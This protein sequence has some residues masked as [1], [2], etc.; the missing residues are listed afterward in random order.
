M[1]NLILHA[2]NCIHLF[3]CLTVNAMVYLSHLIQAFWRFFL[4]LNF[5]MYQAEFALNLMA[6]YCQQGPCHGKCHKYGFEDNSWRSQPYYY[7]LNQRNWD[8]NKLWAIT[9]YLSWSQ[10]CIWWI[11]SQLVGLSL[12]KNGK[13][14]VPYGINGILN[15]WICWYSKLAHIQI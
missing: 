4:S 2:L 10:P 14:C 8:F 7:C 15:V 9:W 12:E 5:E 13:L 6:P 3:I 11:F 1:V